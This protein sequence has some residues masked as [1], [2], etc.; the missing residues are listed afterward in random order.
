[1]IYSL[2]Y[3]QRHHLV[4][5]IL[6][7]VSDTRMS[8]WKKARDRLPESPSQ[9]HWTAEAVPGYQKER[10]KVHDFHSGQSDCKTAQG[11]NRAISYVE[12][13]VLDNFRIELQHKANKRHPASED[14]PP[15]WADSLLKW[16]TGQIKEIAYKPDKRPGT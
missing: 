7:C 4:Q 8:S 16:S 5:Q 10:R 14:H 13:P 3:E 2:N 15:A 12:I 6:R 9:V 1:M 11:R